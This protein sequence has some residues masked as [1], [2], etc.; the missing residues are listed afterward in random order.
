MSTSYNTLT[1]S[2]EEPRKAR[3]TVVYAI[4]GLAVV[5]LAGA[6]AFLVSSAGHAASVTDASFEAARGDEVYCDPGAAGFLDTVPKYDPLFME[7][8]D[9]AFYNAC[10]YSFRCCTTTNNGNGC[11]V[12]EN[13]GL[14]C[15]DCI[16]SNGPRMTRNVCK[17]YL[18]KVDAEGHPWDAD[19]LAKEEQAPEFDEETLMQDIMPEPRT[20]NFILAFKDKTTCWP[21]A[22]PQDLRI[23]QYK[24]KCFEVLSWCNLL[25]PRDAANSVQHNMCKHCTLLGF[26]L[27]DPP[28]KQRIGDQQIAR[29]NI[30]VEKIRVASAAKK[31]WEQ[32]WTK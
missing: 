23:R 24:E 5:A 29:D 22:G 32:R 2:E 6:A 31:D 15:K 17:Q 8:N 10:Y 25:C 7:G 27:A 13:F 11:Y 9:E 12:S 4:L 26:D 1:L 16:G 28:I 3:K 21:Q 30:E 19:T 20:E 14:K 18:D